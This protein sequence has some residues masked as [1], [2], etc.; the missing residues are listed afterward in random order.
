MTRSRSETRSYLVFEG[1]RPCPLSGADDKAALSGRMQRNLDCKT[2]ICRACGFCCVSPLPTR[3]VYDRYYREAYAEHYEPIHRQAAKAELRESPADRALLGSIERHRRLRGANVLEIGAGNG[4]LLRLAA[5]R[6][7]ICSAIEPSTA[8]R[9]ELER[10]G[11]NVIGE[12]LEGTTT[13]RRF[14]VVM[15]YHVLGHFREPREALQ[16][17]RAL[18]VDGGLL[19]LEVADIWHPYRS[20]DRYSLRFVRLS[21]FS[22]GTIGA[23]LASSGFEVLDLGSVRRQTMISPQS[24]RAI[25]ARAPAPETGVVLSGDDWNGLL[26]HLRRYRRRYVLLD[27]PQFYVVSL[28]LS[29]RRTIARTPLGTAYRAIKAR[30]VRGTLGRRKTEPS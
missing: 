12:F 22:T 10:W 5:R 28:A 16:R 30:I 20:L 21:Y 8:F 23:L 29:V 17:T 7:A 4:R 15:L 25:A 27:G 18:L 3:E 14:D 13:D 1:E 6:G 19:F 11:V 9:A 26:A 2:V 24:I